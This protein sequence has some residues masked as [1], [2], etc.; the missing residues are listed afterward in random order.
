M[1]YLV[2]QWLQL[3]K[4]LHSETGTRQIALGVSLGFV[5]GM[6]P[7]LSL[8]SLL[9]FVILLF[10]RVQLGAAFLAAFF[11]KFVAFFLDPAFHSVGQWVLENPSLNPLLTNLYNTALVPWTRFYNSIVMGSGV[12]SF[13]LLPVVFLLSF[14][15]VQKYRAT[16]YMH[17]KDAKVMKLLKATTFYKW[18]SKY[19]Q[20]RN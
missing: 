15:L 19:E 2:Q 3:I 16:V 1:T 4:I 8:Q 12:V 20:F 17:L 10:F 13:L 6:S 11:F 18:Y 5:L 14:W 9:V 7:A